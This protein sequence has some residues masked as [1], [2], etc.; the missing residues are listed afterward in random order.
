ML[1]YEEMAKH[2][3]EIP[4]PE[5]AKNVQKNDIIVAGR[6]FG[7]GS[8]REEAPMVLSVLGI[9]CIIAESFSRL[10]YRNAFNIGLPVLEVE[11][12]TEQI[13]DGQ[14]ITVSLR[15]GTIHIEK[16]DRVVKCRPVPEFM[17]NILRAGGAVQMF[18]LA[19][20]K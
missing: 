2:A 6:N 12:A 15:E 3:L 19:L 5:F 20:S 10:F 1:D 16:R 13:T 18:K 11:H 4:R 17:M 14:R 7:G 8:S 9:G